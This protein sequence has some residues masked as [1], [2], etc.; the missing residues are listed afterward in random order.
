MNR[1]YEG[2]KQNPTIVVAPSSAVETMGLVGLA[3]TNAL[4]LQ[5]ARGRQ[6]KPAPARPAA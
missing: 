6:H 3:G 4:G 5:L 1:L 2:L